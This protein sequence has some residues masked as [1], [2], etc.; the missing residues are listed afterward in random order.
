MEKKMSGKNNIFTESFIFLLVLLEVFIIIG[1]LILILVYLTTQISYWYGL[2]IIPQ[3]YLFILI[4]KWLE[5]E[6]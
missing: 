4:V 5:E 3:L 6:E 2:L 1:S